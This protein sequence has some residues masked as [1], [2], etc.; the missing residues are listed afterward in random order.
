MAILLAIAILVAAIPVAGGA[1]IVDDLHARENLKAANAQLVEARNLLLQAAEE[2]TALKDE[3]DA[4]QATAQRTAAELAAMTGE[5]DALTAKAA[6]V[7][8]AVAEQRVQ[9][10][11][12]LPAD[13][14]EPLDVAAEIREATTAITNLQGTNVQLQSGIAQRDRVNDELRAANRQ[15][16]LEAMPYWQARQAEADRRAA[17]RQLATAGAG[18]G[19]LVILVVVVVLYT[20]HRYN[21][22]QMLTWVLSICPRRKTK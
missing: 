3:R 15:L 22:G 20:D 7:Q 12:P 16:N 21:K 13:A 2:I 19:G 4:A 17:D 10:G 11:V 18:L 9:L 5:R 1:A 6:E 8:V 14:A